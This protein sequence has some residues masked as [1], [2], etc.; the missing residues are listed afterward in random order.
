[1]TRAAIRWIALAWIPATIPACMPTAATPSSPLGIG[2]SP[3]TTPPPTRPTT[4]APIPGKVTAV[5]LATFFPIQQ[6]STALIYD[7]RPGFSYHISHIPGALS[8]PKS[9]FDAQ[10]AAREAEIRS[11]V[12]A[13]RPV[14]LYCTDLSCPDSTKVATRLAALGHSVSILDGGFATWKAA[15][16]PTE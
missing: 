4:V 1:M 2:A 10:L 14:I 3:R 9:Q 15:E 13:K 12:A 5:S 6:S 8:W 16:L 11:A 7:V